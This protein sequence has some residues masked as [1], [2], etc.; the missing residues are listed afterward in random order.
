MET[1]KLGGQERP[2]IFDFYAIVLFGKKCDIKLSEFENLSENM[3]FDHMLRLLDI[4]LE[5]GL[6][7]NQRKDWTDR[8]LA[9]WIGAD[10][11]VLPQV[12]RLIEQG[13]PAVPDEEGEEI[14]GK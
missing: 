6:P 2:V 8:D 5:Q 12:F 3:R 14:E 11:D 4:A 7:Q 10:P 9:N 1:I 13:M